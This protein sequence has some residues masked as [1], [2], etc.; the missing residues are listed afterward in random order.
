MPH[1]PLRCRALII[2]WVCGL[3][4]V[5]LV[6]QESPEIVSLRNN[7]ER[8]NAIAQ[9]NLGLALATG[10]GTPVNPPEAYV[11]LTLAEEKGATG[12]VLR[13]LLGEMTPAQLAE[14]NRLLA[15]VCW[16]V[17]TAPSPKLCSSS[18]GISA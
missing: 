15:A 9:Y 3:F 11:W 13:T 12:R 4:A 5:T 10:R 1:L 17:S 18:T 16:R 2:A 14:G 7:A 8:G 6:A